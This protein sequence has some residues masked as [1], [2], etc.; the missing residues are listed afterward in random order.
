MMI[1][2]Q[3]TAIPAA[4]FMPEAFCEILEAPFPL[5]EGTGRDLYDNT[6]V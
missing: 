1:P 3:V 2:S 6:G 5:V 4:A